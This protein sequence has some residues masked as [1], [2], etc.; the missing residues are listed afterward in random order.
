M[1]IASSGIHPI[2]HRRIEPTVRQGGGGGRGR[3][4]NGGKERG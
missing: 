2:L 4:R 1:L 3:E